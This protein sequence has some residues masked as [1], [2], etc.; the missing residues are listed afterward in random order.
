MRKC[1]YE[2]ERESV[3]TFK[4]QLSPPTYFLWRALHRG[5]LV[6]DKSQNLFRLLPSK[7]K[8][9]KLFF[10]KRSRLLTSF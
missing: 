7:V 1:E 4:S 6:F 3:L 10:E 2:R 5:K 8:A 9:P